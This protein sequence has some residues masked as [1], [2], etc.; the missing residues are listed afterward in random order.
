[1]LTSIVRQLILQNNQGDEYCGL[2]YPHQASRVAAWDHPVQ[3]LIH[4]RTGPIVYATANTRLFAA[5]L[6]PLSAVPILLLICIANIPGVPT[7]P[8]KPSGGVTFNQHIGMDGSAGENG[9]GASK[10]CESLPDTIP[11][12]SGGIL[13]MP[14][15]LL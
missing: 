12:A 4:K 3:P 14:Y 6:H 11:P 15:R 1:V 2:E 10:S 7:P 5:V 9:H 8:D 13:P